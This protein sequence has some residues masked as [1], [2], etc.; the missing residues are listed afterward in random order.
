MVHPLYEETLAALQLPRL[1]CGSFRLRIAADSVNLP[2]QHTYATREALNALLS[3][4][5]DSWTQYY[6]RACLLRLDQGERIADQV[7][8]RLQALQLTENFVLLGMDCE[9]LCG[10]GM[11]IEH[12]LKPRHAIALG[13]TAGCTCYVP[14]DEEIPHG[15]YETESYLWGPWTGPLQLGTNERLIRAFHSLCDRLS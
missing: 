8:V 15:G 11:A 10:L 13:Y 12:A 5:D 4:T 6:V 2:C 1:E 9:P 14:N 7:T 3:E